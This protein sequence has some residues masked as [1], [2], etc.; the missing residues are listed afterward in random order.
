MP[1]IKPLTSG[2]VVSS[3]TDTANSL[4]DTATTAVTGATEAVSTAASESY[5]EGQFCVA[6]GTC[7]DV[8]TDQGRAALVEYMGTT[9]DNEVL[10]DLQEYI[11]DHHEGRN[12]GEIISSEIV[13][14]ILAGFF[15]GRIG[16]AGAGP[17]TAEGR[18]PSI[19]ISIDENTLKYLAKAATSITG[20]GIQF[21]RGVAGAALDF[22][23]DPLGT[24]ASGP[25]GTNKGSLV[26]SGNKGKLVRKE[27]LW[28]NI[29]AFMH[30]WF[31]IEDNG[32]GTLTVNKKGIARSTGEIGFDVVSLLVGPGAAKK[33][34]RNAVSKALGNKPKSVKEA[35]KDSLS[36]AAHQWKALGQSTRSRM[37]LSDL[38]K[39]GV[40]PA[41]KQSTIIAGHKAGK[42]ASPFAPLAAEW[43]T[44]E[45]LARK[46]FDKYGSE[47]SAADRDAWAKWFAFNYV[48]ADITIQGIDWALGKIYS[49]RGNR[50]S[51]VKT[52]GGFITKVIVAEI[53]T[54]AQIIAGIG[55][56]KIQK[57]EIDPAEYFTSLINMDWKK[58]GL[59]SPVTINEMLQA[60]SGETPQGVEDIALVDYNGTQ[61]T[62][63]PTEN[64]IVDSQGKKIPRGHP[65]YQEV[66][67][68]WASQGGQTG[69]KNTLVDTSQ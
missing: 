56:T 28:G 33:G 6:Q 50:A 4:V 16:T 55:I 34:V 24:S 45:A 5:K 25:F 66:W 46:M 3:P 29:P 59:D 32:D 51:D 35:L 49:I 18:P 44:A 68:H 62:I 12:I 17:L 11:R 40:L 8:T 2:T 22:A 63:N 65:L 47:L 58:A 15:S 23:Y 69:S 42:A 26:G 48:W 7:F 14:T 21:V 20:H 43:V 1:E 37:V 19:D 61:Y 60:L 31:E 38:T 9:K 67:D 57:G 64:L 10:Q 53:L 13:N 27:G 30:S 52:I 39:K 41:L 54:G 36:Q